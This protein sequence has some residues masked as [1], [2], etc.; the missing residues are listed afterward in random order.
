MT[1]HPDIPDIAL[2]VMQPWSLLIVD[3]LKPIENRDWRPWNPGLRHRGPVA[4]HAGMKPDA[5]AM[6]DVRHGRHPVTGEPTLMGWPPMPRY[7]DLHE[8]RL[9]GGIV[10]VATLVDVVTRSDSEWFVGPYGLV[11][12][13]A[14]PVPFIPVKGALGF[15]KWRDKLGEAPATK[16]VAG[17]RDDLFGGGAG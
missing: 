13:D 6:D 8:G 2:S 12:A 15:F 3:G 17:L 1:V 11:F 16:P 4:I 5:G 7:F 14:R 9:C 10:G